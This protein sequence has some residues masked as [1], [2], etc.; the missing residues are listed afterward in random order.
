MRRRRVAAGA[1]PVLGAS[2]CPGTRAT[3]ELSVIVPCYNEE[4][5]LPELVE[6]TAAGV[7]APRHRGRARPGERRQPRRHG[8]P[9]RRSG[10]R[11]AIR[12]GRCPPS[13]QPAASRPAGGAASSA[14]AGATCAPST[15]ICSTSPRR[16]RCSTARCASAAPISC[17]AGAA[18]SSARHDHPLLPEPGARLLLKLAFAHAGARREVGLRALSA[19]GVRGHPP[20]RRRFH[21]F[22]HMITVVAKAKRLLDPAGRD[23]LRRAP[24]RAVVHQ[25]LPAVM[26]MART[27]VDIGRAVVAYR[28]REPKDQSLE[29]ALGARPPPAQPAPRTARRAGGAVPG[30]HR[31]RAALPGR[32]ARA[33]SGCRARS[34]SSCSC[35]A[36]A[37]CWRMRP[38]TSATGARCC[39]SARLGRRRRPHARRPAT[40]SPSLTQEAVRENIYFDL[41]S[42]SS[43]KRARSR[44]VTTSGSDAASRSRSFVDRLQRDIRWAN[45]DATPR[46]GGPARGGGRP[47]P[48][49][50]PS[51]A[52]PRAER[53]RGLVPRAR[54]AGHRRDRARVRR[55]LAARVRASAARR[56]SRP[57]PRCSASSRR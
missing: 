51:G 41:L 18:P 45:A 17:R 57:T 15:P 16:S 10:A 1:E 32:A 48:R 20:E 38:T 13:D 56:C 7:R 25:R 12:R 55:A 14:R 49:P 46:L 3:V 53:L 27:L 43:G 50:R 34:S 42:D 40:R 6:R 5:N 33:R 54:R 30:D 35:G 37:G 39:S 4:G 2:P 24:R 9:D 36:C 21:Y 19:R 44:K 22:Q 31:Q 8:R 28:L 29:P 26:M 23:A 52:R 11:R 47:A